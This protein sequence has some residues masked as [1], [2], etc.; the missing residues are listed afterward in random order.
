MAPP[1]RLNRA[2]PPCLRSIVQ[3]QSGWIVNEEE[4]S[5]YVLT[6][7][8][9]DLHRHVEYLH[10]SGLSMCVGSPR[11]AKFFCP[12]HNGV[13]DKNGNVVSGPPPRRWTAMKPSGKRSVIH[14]REDSM[15]TRNWA[16]GWMSDSVGA[17]FGMRSSC[18]KFP[19]S[20]GCIRWAAPACS[21]R[22]TRSS[23]GYLLTIYYVPTPDHAYDSVQYHHHP[24]PGGLVDPRPAPLGR[25][26][27]GG[28]HRSCTC[29]GSSCM[30]P[31]STRVRSPGSPA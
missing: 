16:P 3:R 6:D 20:T 22:S 26:C 19:R 4:I 12:C 15:T 9:R 17:R 2:H 5:V 11:T 29:C 28:Y 13:F 14:Q 30:A 8:G 23:P 24:G 27:H 10:P 18:A 7:D 25:Q 31:T 21:W 1:R